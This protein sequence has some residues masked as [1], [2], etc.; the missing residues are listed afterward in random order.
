MDLDES[1]SSFFVTTI[2]PILLPAAVANL[3]I[4]KSF[5][6][7]ILIAHQLHLLYYNHSSKFHTL[8]LFQRVSNNYKIMVYKLVTGTRNRWDPVA[9]G[10]L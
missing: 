6:I 2:Y 8:K 4:N 9:F 3:Y 1:F 5:T 7:R 10:L